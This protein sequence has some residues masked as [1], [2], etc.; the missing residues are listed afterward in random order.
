MSA[1]AIRERRVVNVADVQDMTQGDYSPEMQRVLAVAG[2]RSI[3]C[4]PLIRDQDVLGALSVGRAEVGLFADKEVTLLQTFARQAVVAI[5]NVRLFNETQEALEQQTA[6]AGVLQVIS[7]SMADA[8]PVFEKIL[9]S[10]ARLLR[11]TRMLMLRAGDDGLL[12]LWAAAGAGEPATC[13]GTV[14]APSTSPARR[15]A[16]STT[17]NSRCFAPSPTR[18]WSPSRMRVP[19]EGR[20]SRAQL[21]C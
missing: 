2:W 18:R 4:A 14:S 13:A 7:G 19:H 1:R 5:E 8:Q 16:R 17:R 3:L 15:R 21:R 12:H 9:D 11:S 6:T 10:C 20:L